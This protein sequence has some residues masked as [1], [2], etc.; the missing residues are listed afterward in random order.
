MRRQ[1]ERQAGERKRGGN[2]L[3]QHL[4]LLRELGR[5]RLAV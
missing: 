5:E 2:P 3:L 1:R 4:G